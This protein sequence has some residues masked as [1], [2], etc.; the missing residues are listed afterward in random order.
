MRRKEDTGADAT[1]E[2]PACNRTLVSVGQEPGDHD[3][4]LPSGTGPAAAH[5]S[6]H[7]APGRAPTSRGKN[8]RRSSA[9]FSDRG[10]TVVK[11]I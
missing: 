5:G 10:E 4:H 11:D 7:S 2:P 9:L 1:E 3:R 6:V 8:T